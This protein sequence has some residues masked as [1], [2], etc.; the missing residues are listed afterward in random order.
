MYYQLVTSIWNSYTW[1]EGSAHDS[2]VLNDALSRRNGLKVPPGLHNFLRRECRSDEFPIEPDN[3]SSS[4][5]AN[6]DEF[7]PV[8]QTQEEQHEIGNQW[9]ASIATNMWEDAMQNENNDNDAK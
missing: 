6:K 9:R 8:F 1:W 5:P 7:E 3:E 2:R 4:P